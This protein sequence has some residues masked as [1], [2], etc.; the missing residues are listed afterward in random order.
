MSAETQALLPSALPP[1]PA[2]FHPHVVHLTVTSWLLPFNITSKF[3]VGDRR[4]ATPLTNW[5]KVGN[6]VTLSGKGG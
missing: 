2:G 1:L 6:V 4:R 5:P 3:T